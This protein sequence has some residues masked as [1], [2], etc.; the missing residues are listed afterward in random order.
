M[1]KK[2]ASSSNQYID[3]EIYWVFSSQEEIDELISKIQPEKII[4]NLKE[5]RKANDLFI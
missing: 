5:K 4:E 2:V 1:Y 3:E